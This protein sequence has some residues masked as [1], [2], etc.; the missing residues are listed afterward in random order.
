MFSTC[1]CF[2][3]IEDRCQSVAALLEGRNVNG[4]CRGY[5]RAMVQSMTAAGAVPHFHY[6]DEVS[7]GHLLRLRATLLSDP[8]LQGHKLTFLPFML[9]VCTFLLHLCNVSCL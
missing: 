8:A 2:S 4:M 9:K 3:D 5:R 7:M 6:C 1:N